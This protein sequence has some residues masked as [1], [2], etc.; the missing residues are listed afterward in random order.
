MSAV[1]FVKEDDFPGDFPD[2][3]KFSPLGIADGEGIMNI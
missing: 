2:W 3:V 1:Q